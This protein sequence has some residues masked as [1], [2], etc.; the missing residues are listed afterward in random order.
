MPSDFTI[1]FG[2][3]LLQELVVKSSDFAIAVIRNTITTNQANS[4]PALRN[5]DT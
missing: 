4:I 1:A 5:L 2:L 3:K